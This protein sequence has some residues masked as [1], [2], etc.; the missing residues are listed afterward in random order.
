VDKIYDCLETRTLPIYLG[1]PDVEKYI[2]PGCFINFRKF[3]NYRELDKYLQNLDD[4]TYLEYIRNIDQW[5]AQGGLRPLSMYAIH[6]YIVDLLISEKRIPPL[7]FFG[8]SSEWSPDVTP[9]LKEH[10]WNPVTDKTFWTYECLSQ[11]HSPLMDYDKEKSAITTSNRHYLKKIGYLRQNNNSSKASQEL[12]KLFLN[13]TFNSELVYQQA[14][15]FIDMSRFEESRNR[16]KQVL[17]MNPCHSLA[18]N[19]LGGLCMLKKD[20]VKAVEL[21]HAAL[22]NNVRNNQALENLISLLLSLNFKDY[23]AELIQKLTPLRAGDNDFLAIL[24]KYNLTSSPENNKSSVELK[25][26]PEED[27]SL[28]H[29]IC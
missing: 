4:Q 20:Y 19:D 8:E 13:G 24:K 3:K 17:M 5:V 18:L 10:R 21:L 11:A 15:L 16:L 1:A 22:S 9:E 23:L 2:P 6:E 26:I 25:P 27:G 12:E 29:G 28:G 7:D 14:Q